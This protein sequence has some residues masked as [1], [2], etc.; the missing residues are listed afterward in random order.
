MRG[1]RYFL[2]ARHILTQRADELAVFLGHAVADGVGN[3]DR[4]GARCDHGFDYL[5]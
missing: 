5:A 2:D 1:D 4:G 3:V